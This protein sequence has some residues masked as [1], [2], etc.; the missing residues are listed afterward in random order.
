MTLT[1][2]TRTTFTCIGL[3]SAATALPSTAFAQDIMPDMPEVEVLSEAETR[4]LP[5]DLQTAPTRSAMDGEVSIGADGVETITRTRRITRAVP[6]ADSANAWVE[7]EEYATPVHTRHYSHAYAP[8]AYA[9]GAQVFQREQWVAECERR[10]DGHRGRKKGGIIGGLLGAI[11]GGIIGN[12]LWDSER[13]AGTLIGVG[14]GGIGGALLGGL[15]GGGRNDRGEYD[16]EA[17]L[18]AYLSQYSHG[19][20]RIAARTIPAP[21]PVYAAPPVYAP[22]AYGYGYAAPQYYY[23]PPQQITYVPIDYQQRQRVIVRETVREEV[24]PG[25]RREI[26][27]PPPPRPMPA[28][29]PIKGEPRMIKG[30]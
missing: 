21:A 25:A 18:D 19:A 22:P 2:R 1:A 9:P 15:I 11:A 20:P 27:A 14:A 26:P 30:N 12:R 7:R 23:A 13:L 6:A 16:C 17:A 3:A 24:I 28:P 4:T 10:T 29:R 5:V 8:A